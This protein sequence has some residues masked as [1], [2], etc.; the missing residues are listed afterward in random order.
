MTQE[1]IIGSARSSEPGRVT[2]RLHIGDAPDGSPVEIPVVIVQGAK[3]GK[4]LWLHGCV[5]GNEYCGT[6]IIHELLGALDPAQ[7]AGTVV[8]LPIL[9]LPAF[10]ARQ[11]T[12][13]FELYH[14]GDM[15]RQFPGD[16]NGTHTQQMAAKIYEPLKRYA[17]VLVDFHTAMTPDVSWALYPK[18][19]GEVEALSEKVARAFGLR[20]TLPAPP[21]ILNGSAMMTAAKDGIA[22]YIVECG[23]KMRGFTDESV[24]DSVARLKNVMIALGMLEGTARDHGQLNYFSNFAWVTATRGGLFEKAVSCGDRIE[25]GTV[26][27]RYYDAWG[28]GKGEA[29][30]PQPGIV[31]AIHPGPV[32]ATGETLVHIGL[33]PRQV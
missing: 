9:N 32:M 30:S 19:G 25:V 33:D 18:V 16:P 26:L 3:P 8:A 17:D 21:T 1:I 15:N 31:L 22:S 12:S 13:P 10:Q 14:G 11:R 7:L 6:Y 29:T 27:G 2:G 24:T 4:V 23:G 20:D 5:H 28:N